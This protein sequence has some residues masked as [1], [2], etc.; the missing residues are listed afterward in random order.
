MQ[1]KMVIDTRHCVV[2]L[3]LDGDLSLRQCDEHLLLAFVCVCAA[4]LPH[5]VRQ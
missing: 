1:L 4:W 2:N 3:T 5:P